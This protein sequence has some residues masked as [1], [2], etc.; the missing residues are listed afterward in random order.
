M[1]PSQVQADAANDS[2]SLEQQTE[3]DAKAPKKEGAPAGDKPAEG[4]DLDIT[5]ATGGGSST[6]PQEPKISPLK[7]LWRKFNVY[8]LLFILVV[9]LGI[10]IVVVSIVKSKQA[11]KTN[12][13]TQ[14][15]SQSDLRQLATT[16][17]TVGSPKQVLTVQ[18]N[19]VFSGGVLV[20]SNLEVAGALRV[21]G[22]L[23]LSDIAVSG[24]AQLGDTQ[25]NN[26]TVG[27]TLNLSGALNIKNGLSVSG[28]TNFAGS[29]TATA[30]TTGALQLNGDLN[31]THHVIA[32][33]TIPGIS[34]GT[35]VGGGGTV[36]LSGSDTSGSITINTGG[37]PPAG[38]FASITFSQKFT[39]TPHIVLTPIGSGA[40]GLQ[41][42][43]TR[44]TTGFDICSANSAPG[45]QTFGFD[46]IALG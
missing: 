33:G 16:D 26:L 44:S 32:G 6:A 40:A 30:V 8:L 13:A 45:G 41:Y 9:V 7:K 37:S 14:G 2:H 35:A 39:S 11:A 36:S 18:A 25:V 31:L 4:G 15:L 38:C 12:I 19:A 20:R 23:S 34:K 42:Y 17:V 21:G 29:L 46:Y 43:V 1:D 10:G 24:L 27:G 5:D 28:S 3:G 22:S